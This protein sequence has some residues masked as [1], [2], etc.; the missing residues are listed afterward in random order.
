[1]LNLIK[2]N[3]YKK[4]KFFFLLYVEEFVLKDMLLQN[5]DSFVLIDQ[6]VTMHKAKKEKKSKKFLFNKNKK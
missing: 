3:F 6:Q 1:M 2:R 5:F 4:I